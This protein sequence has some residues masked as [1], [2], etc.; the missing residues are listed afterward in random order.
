MF[1]YCI[2]LFGA[3]GYGMGAGW[4]GGLIMFVGFILIGVIIYVIVRN[5]ERLAKGDIDEETYHH[6]SNKIK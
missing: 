1:N 2:W 6:L 5:N 3:G 4:I